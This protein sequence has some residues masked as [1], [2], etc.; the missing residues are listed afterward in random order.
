M[1][2][3]VSHMDQGLA[4]LHGQL[5]NILAKKTLHLKMQGKTW[6]VKRDYF[7]FKGDQ[8]RVSSDISDEKGP[9]GLHDPIC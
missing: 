6:L 5:T 8:L 4:Q 7:H 3:A 2:I 9:P 1:Y